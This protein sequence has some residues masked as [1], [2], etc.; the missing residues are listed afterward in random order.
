[1]HGAHILAEKKTNIVMLGAQNIKEESNRVQFT[2]HKNI[3]IK[4]FD[5]NPEVIRS[6]A[7]KK[8]VAYAGISTVVDRIL[9]K[10][11]KLAKNIVRESIPI[12]KKEYY[13]I[14][15]KKQYENKK[16]DMGII[17]SGLKQHNTKKQ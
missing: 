6:L 9:K 16:Q 17:W 11:P 8:I 15:S 12:R 1:M 2:T 3:K 14:F 4:T 5:E 7:N 10:Y 13:I